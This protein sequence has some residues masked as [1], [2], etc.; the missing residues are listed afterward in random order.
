MSRKLLRRRKGIIFI[1]LF[2]VARAQWEAGIEMRWSRK[3][4]E[5]ECC[6]RKIVS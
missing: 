1:R 4:S 2:L 6:R 5:R 3:K